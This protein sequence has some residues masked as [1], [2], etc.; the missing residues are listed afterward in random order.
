MVYAYDKSSLP[1]GI[2]GILFCISTPHFSTMG[3]AS[4]WHEASFVFVPLGFLRSSM[5]CWK[6]QLFMMQIVEKYIVQVR[7]G[8]PVACEKGMRQIF[9]YPN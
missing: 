1:Q 7:G 5:S 3:H 6:K 9:R 8:E 2:L 4:L